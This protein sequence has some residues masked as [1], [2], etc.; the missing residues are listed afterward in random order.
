[1]ATNSNDV[2]KK[3]VVAIELVGL[4]AEPTTKAP[5]KTFKA[6]DWRPIAGARTWLE[7]LAK[8]FYVL[9]HTIFVNPLFGDPDE[10]VDR[11]QKWMKTWSLPFDS[12]HA[13]VGKPVAERYINFAEDK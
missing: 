13:T 8:T 2:S 12:I 1:M 5:C 6:S 3:P 9:I 4:L 7:D 10:T 11:I